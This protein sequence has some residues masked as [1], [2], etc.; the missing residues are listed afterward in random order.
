MRDKIKKLLNRDSSIVSDEDLK[1]LTLEEEVKELRKENAQLKKKACDQGI[2]KFKSRRSIRKFS[3]K[4]V[5]FKKI[6]DI[7]EAGLNAPCA[8]N[9][10]NYKIIIVEQ[11]DKKIEC[12]KIAIQQYWLSE[13]PYL[14]VVVREDSEL[15]SLYPVRGELYSIQNVAA[16]IENMVMAAHFHDLGTCWVEAGDNEVLKESLG[17]PIECKIDAIIPVG[18]PLE[19]PQ[20]SKVETTGLLFF[21][22]WGERHR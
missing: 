18:Y 16:V 14:I 12:G 5:D 6:C 8:G 20:V 7:V 22:K 11:K 13:A 2:D 4:P 3:T 21:E 10:Q 17:V 19:N 15:L 9:V 1:E